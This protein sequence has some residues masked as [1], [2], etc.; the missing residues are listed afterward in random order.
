YPRV[1]HHVVMR[2]L[3]P[4]VVVLL[5][6]VAVAAGAAL[7]LREESGAALDR[8]D[9]VLVGDSLSVGTLDYLDTALPGWSVRSDSVVGRRTADGL[10]ALERLG[11]REPVVISLGTNDPAGAAETFRADVERALRL[12]G[13]R[14]VIW[15][16][17]WRAGGPDAAFND[18][19]EQAAESGRLQ[20][21]RWDEMLQRD[22]ALLAPDGIHGSP[23]GY[24]ARA[25]EV[26]RL[27]RACPRSTSE[28]G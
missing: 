18:V 27:V 8:G 4:A 21:L 7:L 5:V 20:L 13:G 1:G 23:S 22:P 14:C 9:V 2:S 19:L 11:G 3:R 17:I 15:A 24:A 25:A 26:A 16:T 6:V 12:A 28:A 10:A